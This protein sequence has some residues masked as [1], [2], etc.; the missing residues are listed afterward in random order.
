MALF[1]KSLI[2]L[3]AKPKNIHLIGHSLGCHVASLAAKKINAE[4]GEPIGRI[5]AMDPAQPLYD[6]DGQPLAKLTKLD[7]SDA[8]LVGKGF[9]TIKMFRFINLYYSIS[10]LLD[11]HY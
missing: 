11:D 3:G 4:N 10:H 7:K 6:Y 1:L 8:K 5:S 9:L 2:V